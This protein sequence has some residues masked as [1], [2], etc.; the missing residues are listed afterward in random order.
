MKIVI[1]ESIW[2][3][4]IQILKEKGWTV[5]YDPE[6]WNDPERISVELENADALIVRNQTQV[7]EELLSYAKR[8]KVVGRLGVGLDNI[9]VNFTSEKKIVVV[10]GKNANATS[11][12]EYVIS[13]LFSNYRL[14]SQGS[15]DVKKGNWDR[16]RFTGHEAFGK[17]LG[18]IGIG[19]I[20]HRTAVRAKALGVRVLGYDPYVTPYDFPVM[21]SEIQLVSLEEVIEKSDFVSL[22]VPLTSETKNL[23]NLDI[24]GKMKPSSVI[25]NTS[26]GG[27]I[28]EDDLYIALQNNVIGGAVLD[29]LEKEPPSLNH[30][31]LHLDNCI[32]TPHIAGLTEESQ[33]RTSKMVVGEVIK[34]LEGKVSL[35]RVGIKR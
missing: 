1:T 5:T 10:F 16:K 24:M 28:N 22:H 30:P 25:I 20:G 26:R 15:E 32:I 35:C 21:E 34:E 2:P 14:L 8:L 19:E 31:L 33:V 3:I 29:V 12:A 17:T 23:I 4:G 18:L 6:L 9:D 27:I 7:N 13:A 11:V